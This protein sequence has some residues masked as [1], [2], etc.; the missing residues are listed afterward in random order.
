MLFGARSPLR[1]SRGPMTQPGQPGARARWAPLTRVAAN[2]AAGLLY[3]SA[4]AAQLQLEDLQ[5]GTLE[6]L[7]AVDPI[8]WQF[9]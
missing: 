6:D 8:F 2:P 5:Q 1:L 3:P 4:C 7:S 9:C